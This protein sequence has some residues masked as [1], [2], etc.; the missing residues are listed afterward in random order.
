M[1]LVCQ[2]PCNRACPASYALT[3]VVP[4]SQN[5][6]VPARVSMNPSGTP[7]RPDL[8]YYPE[9]ERK[10]AMVQAAPARTGMPIFLCDPNTLT[11]RNRT[12]DECFHGSALGI[13]ITSCV[14][15]TRVNSNTLPL[16]SDFR[17]TLERKKPRCRK[18]MSLFSSA[19]MISSS[20]P[21][22]LLTQ[23]FMVPTSRESVG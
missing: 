8:E 19:R 14:T 15:E 21:V 9:L 5:K 13:C 12:L 1:I 18:S 20:E 16:K 22:V 6:G 23:L 10:Q 4:E 17:P 11:A 3:D 2:P 7:E